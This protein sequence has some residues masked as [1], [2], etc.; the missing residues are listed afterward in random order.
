MEQ[1][2]DNMVHPQKRE[3]VLVVLELVIQ[4]VVQLKHELVKWNQARAEGAGPFPWEYVGLD[5]VLVDMKLPPEALDVPVPAYFKENNAAAI[6]LRDRLLASYMQLK[7]G[8]ESMALEADEEFDTPPAEITLEQVGT[9]FR[10]CSGMEGNPAR[11][12]NWLS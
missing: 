8:D 6:K 2:Y 5:D 4:R 7:H 11:S 1:C 10:L 9:V 12:H 3:Q